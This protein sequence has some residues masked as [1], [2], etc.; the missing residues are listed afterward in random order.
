MSAR[1]SP[2]TPRQRPCS[3]CSPVALTPVPR[4]GLD[5]RTVL[6]LWPYHSPP[7]A[8]SWPPAVDP[9]YADATLH[10]LAAMLPGLAA[11]FDRMPRPSIDAGYYTKTTENR[12]LICPLPGAGRLRHRCVIGFWAD[13]VLWRRR[14]CLPLTSTGGRLPPYAPA[15]SLERYADPAYLKLLADWEGAGQL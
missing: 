1:A 4:A 14:L 11:Y 13:G 2:A 15:F 3:G 8:P 5:A 12:P 10:G 9:C 7:V 6:M